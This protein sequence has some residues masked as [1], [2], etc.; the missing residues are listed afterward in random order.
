MKSS[1]RTALFEHYITPPEK[2]FPRFKLGAM[3]FLLGLI[4]IYCGTQLL[5]P[6]LLQEVNTLVGLLLVGGGF[7]MAL[8]AQVRMVIG[9]VLRFFFRNPTE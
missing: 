7:L 5:E 8:M 4:V 9:R 6:S 2:V 1:L 3:I